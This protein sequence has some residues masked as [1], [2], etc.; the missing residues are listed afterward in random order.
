V[1]RVNV[2]GL[3]RESPGTVRDVIVDVPATDLDRSGPFQGPLRGL[4]RL[5]RT[6]RGVLISGPVAAAVTRTCVRCLD[7]FSADARITLE[8]EFLPSVDVGNGAPVAVHPADAEIRRIDAGQG[9][10]LGPLIVEELLLAEPMHAL[11]REDCPG[12][13]PGCGRHMDTG[14]C[15]CE[16]VTLDPRLAVLARFRAPKPP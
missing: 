6:N 13:C 3:L 16:V 2:A 7:D 15:D 12:L 8:E 5:Q 10:D 9:L 4:M 14:S 1:I 11:C